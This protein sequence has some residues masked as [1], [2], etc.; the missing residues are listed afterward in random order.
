MSRQEIGKVVDLALRK[1][2]AHLRY[3]SFLF[4]NHSPNVPDPTEDSFPFSANNSGFWVSP[5]YIRHHQGC[6]LLINMVE[7]RTMW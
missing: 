1:G 4:P 3:S 5:L 6:T 2:K 7:D